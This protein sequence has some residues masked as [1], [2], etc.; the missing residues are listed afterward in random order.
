MVQYRHGDVFLR[1]VSELPAGA[2][3][4]AIDGDVILAHGEVTGHAHRIRERTVALWSVAEQR[5][6]TV[7]GPATLTHEEHGPIALEPGIYEVVRQRE[8]APDMN[9]W[10]AD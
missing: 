2:V 3:R 7:D 4:E 10:V 9:R 6:L 1:K 8:Y 5:Y